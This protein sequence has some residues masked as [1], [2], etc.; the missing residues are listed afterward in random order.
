MEVDTWLANIT[1]DSMPP[2][3]THSVISATEAPY[4]STLSSEADP[5][6]VQYRVGIQAAEFIRV[7]PFSFHVCMVNSLML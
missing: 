3:D 7:I 4:P 5:W 6:T 2:I 1:P